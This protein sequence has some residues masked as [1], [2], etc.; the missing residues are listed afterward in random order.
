MWRPTRRD[1]T[2][3]RPGPLPRLP[4]WLIDRSVPAHVAEDVIGDLEQHWHRHRRQAPWRVGVRVW[5]VALQ[6]AWHGVRD[7]LASA[8][9]GRGLSGSMRD[10]WDDIRFAFRTL[11]RFKLYAFAS[12]T[13]LA[14]AIG[15]TTAVL[16][17]IDATLLRPLPFADPDR[18]VSLSSNQTGPDGTELAFGL[19]QIELIGFRQADSAFAGIDAIE[20]RVLGLTGA[21]EPATVQVGAAT[22]GVFHT[23]GIAPAMGRM[24]TA[25]EE[26]ANAGLAVLSHRI[27]S[28]RFSARAD[29]VGQ[30][31]TLG[32][33]SYDIVGVMPANLRLLVDRSDVWIPLN[34][35]IDAARQ[36]IRMMVSFGRLRDGVTLDRA[37]AE[38]API[39]AGLARDWPL[40][41]ARATPRVVTLQESLYGQREPALWMLG[42]TVLGLL[43]LACANVANLTLSHLSARRAELATRVLV[44]AGRWRVIRLLLTQTAVMAA[45]GGGAGL[46]AVSFGLTPLVALYN[47]DGQGVVTLGVDGRV[48]GLTLAVITAATLLSAVVPALRIHGAA[49]AGELLRVASTRASAGPWERRMRAALVTAQIGIAVALLCMSATLIAS[50]RTVLT[51]APGFAADRVLTMQ[52][53]LP[54]AVYPDPAARAGVVSRMLERIQAVPGVAAVGTTQTT[55]L[56]NQG[57]FT[58]MHVEG[59]STPDAERSHIRHITPGYFDA[60]RVRVLEGRPIDERDRMN[61]PLV[62]NVSET[63]AKTFFPAGTAVGHRVRRAGQTPVWMTVVGIVADVRDNGLANVPLPTLY[64][65]YYQLNT[66]TARVSVV[67]RTSGDTVAM[68][69]A[70]R[71]AIWSVDRTQPI[72]R[73]LPLTEVLLEG[74]SAERFRALLVGLFAVI[75]LALAVVG[76]YA[77]AASAVVARTFEASLRLALGARPWRLV[78]GMLREAGMQAGAGV[79][80]GIGGYAALSGL[81]AELLFHT[82]AADP[83]IVAGAAAVMLVSSI[84]AALMQLRRLATVSPALGLRGTGR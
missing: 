29:I 25:D 9:D 16:S 69:P 60:L 46:L 68:A 75:G 11:G 22:S 39:A 26:R 53:L 50:L 2:R 37:R 82:S 8:R 32:G 4:I 78:A 19:S 21:G 83:A 24:F 3:R 23:L 84:G 28:E 43:G 45:L 70:I 17:V 79:A 73:V 65:P 35:V 34:P 44:G 80:L 33:R 42:V 58:M 36:N 67:A 77:V 6:V 59:G 72:D 40:G 15:A 56:P 51:I 57:M 48:I 49:G 20:P 31:I 5:T 13:T 14:L 41:H 76:V 54:P 12:I 47:G 18:L 7:R 62:C 10:M 38:L 55:F 61:A 30:A 74:A 63:F 1:A 64:V 52:I 27:W 81:I 66:P 71:A